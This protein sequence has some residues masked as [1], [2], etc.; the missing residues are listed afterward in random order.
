ME[1]ESM[2]LF[3]NHVPYVEAFQIIFPTASLIFTAAKLFH[4]LR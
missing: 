1:H 3:T 4:Q 2:L